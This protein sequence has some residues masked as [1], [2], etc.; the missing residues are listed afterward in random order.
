[1]HLRFGSRLFLPDFTIFHHHGFAGR[2]LC[3]GIIIV[4]DL[5]HYGGYYSFALTAGFTSLIWACV[6]HIYWLFCCWRR[7]WQGSVGFWLL[8][9]IVVIVVGHVVGSCW[10][11][12]GFLGLSITLFLRTI[13]LFIVII[14]MC[15]FA[16]RWFL[17]L[18]F[19]ILHLYTLLLIHNTGLCSSYPHLFRSYFQIHIPELIIG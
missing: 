2:S 6:C 10:W 8:M 5:L 15:W 7:G 12:G 13:F 4:L 14:L 9:D 11:W 1:M 17:T 18:I 3:V 16:L 19:L